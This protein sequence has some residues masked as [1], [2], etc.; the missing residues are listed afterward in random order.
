MV[1][2][3]PEGYF[4]FAHV[5]GKQYKN[6]GSQLLIKPNNNVVLAAYFLYSADMDPGP[7]NSNI[8]DSYSMSLIIAEY[9]PTGNF[10]KAQRPL[11]KAPEEIYIPAICISPAGDYWIS[12]L[13]FI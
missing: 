12:D 2:I 1:K 5:F 4:S 9:T 11:L 7:G 3:S 10:V 13:N 6:Y 8:S